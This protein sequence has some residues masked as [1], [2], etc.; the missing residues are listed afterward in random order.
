MKKKT[1]Y[2]S[3]GVSPDA[4]QEQIKKAFRKKAKALHPDI[5]N[6]D[7]KKAEEFREVAIAWDLLSDPRARSRYDRTGETEG[8]SE[9]AVEQ[10]AVGLFIQEVT[11]KLAV[12]TDKI[13]TDIFR[14]VEKGLRTKGSEQAKEIK[15]KKKAA[16]RIEKFL[17]QIIHKKEKES[18]IHQALEVQ[19]NQVLMSIGENK[20]KIKVLRFARMLAK[21]YQFVPDKQP[22]SEFGTMQYIIS[23]SRTNTW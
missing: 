15:E 23:N 12:S 4:T 1:P 20:Q 22:V 6:G 21:E 5:T 13:Y 18:L 10:Q 8:V 7:A 9:S 19:K 16:K 3:L 2:E 17:S 11:N 14:N